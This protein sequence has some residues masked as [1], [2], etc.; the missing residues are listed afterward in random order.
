MLKLMLWRNIQTATAATL[1]VAI[2][3]AVGTAPASAANVKTFNISGTFFNGYPNPDNSSV[4][5]GYGTEYGFL[6]RRGSFSG[7]FT[8]DLDKPFDPYDY[9]NNFFKKW[10]VRV[11]APNG[12]SVGRFRNIYL[13]NPA[14]DDIGFQS[15]NGIAFIGGNYTGFW[16]YG[17]PKYIGGIPTYG[18]FSYAS[19]IT[20]SAITYVNYFQISEPYKAFGENTVFGEKIVP[21]PFSLGG[22]ALAGAMGLWMKRKRKASQSA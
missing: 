13:G 5:P 4:V 20:T 19:T 15:Q 18:I 12:Q 9:L 2:L 14:P 10:D 8:A 22:T 11:F 1:G 21:E 6:A 17:T 16:L 7:S 3:A